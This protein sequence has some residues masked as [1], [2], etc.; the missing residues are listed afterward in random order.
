MSQKPESPD[1]KAV[2]KAGLI[3]RLWAMRTT[4]FGA[5]GIMMAA[6]TL[7]GLLNYLFTVVMSHML[8]EAGAFS[9]FNS[10]NSIFLIVVLGALSIQ[11]VI[12]KYVAEFEVT[13]ERERVRFLLRKGAWWL[14]A[15][16][17]VITLVS[18]AAAWPLADALKLSS[19]LLVVLL[20][21]SVAITLYM[22]LPAG[23]LQGEQRF[24][25]LGIASISVAALRIF[26]GVV[27]VK[28]GFGVYGALSAATLAGIAVVGTITYMY[29]DM[30]LGPVVPDETFKP[31]TA[32]SALIPVATA[33]FVVILMTQIDVV[34]VRAFKSEVVADVYSK[35][36]IAGK[37][38]F[39]F[40]EGVALVMFPRVS[41]M[42][43][44]GEPTRRVLGL[45][46]AAAGVLVVAVVGFFALFPG[47]TA[48]FFA[49]KD[50]ARVSALEPVLGVN[51]VVMFGVIMAVY[52]L[53]K[54]LAFYHLALDRVGFIVIYAVAAALE[55]VGIVVFHRT[56]QQILTVM[57]VV[58]VALLAVNLL[59]A[60]E[61]KPGRGFRKAP[62][63][64][65]T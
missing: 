64:P 2:P 14:L 5:F 21:T 54:L 61:E 37:A 65:K 16:G 23:M 4:L 53:V 60:L 7:A 28:L 59:L 58:G 18:V 6:A 30:F 17:A 12:T 27:L 63:V 35:A 52:A 42:R 49:G 19:P 34:L 38:V 36:A 11:T 46:L 48:S 9:S 15:V 26:F 44:R 1:Q 13:G 31:A 3:A 62:V 50:A 40:P 55:I 43:E 20:G 25:A 24:L 51:F 41:A 8:G 29:R 47:F 10:L 33:V 56:L 45:S 57:L 22:T 32:L 39:F